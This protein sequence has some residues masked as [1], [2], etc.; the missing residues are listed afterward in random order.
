MAGFGSISLAQT[1]I[2]TLIDQRAIV[3][4]KQ[5][6]DFEGF[7][8][9][10]LQ[11]YIV[12]DLWGYAFKYEELFAGLLGGL[13]DLSAVA[14]VAGANP[15]GI[16]YMDAKVNIESDLCE[17][18]VEDGTLI[19]DASIIMPVTAEVN[20]AMPTF[21]AQQIYKQMKDMF[22]KKD[23]KII[24]QTKYGVY[25]NLVIQNMSYEL[26]K[27]TI[28]RTVFTLTLREV[29]EVPV[30]GDFGQFVAEAKRVVTPSD[31]NT[32]NTGTQ[33]AIGG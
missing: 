24:L 8:N 14:N 10:W 29:Q 26:D 13:G 3:L 18:P 33:M 12:G 32:I 15:Y 23:S 21:F 11:K 19:T 1:V 25:N 7:D 2:G 28:D 27:D 6:N 4:Y 31:S 30:Y 20:V 22:E 5:P 17:H 16:T 9:G